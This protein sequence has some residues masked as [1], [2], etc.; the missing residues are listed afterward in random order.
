M[1]FKSFYQYSNKI[2]IRNILLHS[3]IHNKF[4]FVV[5]SLRLMTLGFYFNIGDSEKT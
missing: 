3:S 5:F 4:I 1:K 2:L